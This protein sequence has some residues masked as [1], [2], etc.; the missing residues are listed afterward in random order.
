MKYRT[1]GSSGLTVYPVGLGCMGLSQSYPP[2]PDR[3]EA[4]AFLRREV[5][6]GE[7]FFDTS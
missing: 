5:E 1:L 7:T 4:M 3:R 2:F 6:M